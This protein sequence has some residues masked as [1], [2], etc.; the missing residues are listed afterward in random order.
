MVKKAPVDLHFGGAGMQQSIGELIRQARRQ[1]NITQTELGGLRF[2][3]SYVSAVERNK[4][5]S[6][7]DALQFFA[8][9]LGQPGDY[10]I[11]LHQQFEAEGSQPVLNMP[12]ISNQY[13]GEALALLD[14]LLE[15]SESSDFPVHHELP[16]LAPELLATLP[17]HKQS[18]YYF[19]Q[20]L[21]AKVRQDLPAA[22]RSFEAALVFATDAQ[23]AL[24]LDEL[25][26]YYYLLG[27][28][29]TALNYHSRALHVLTDEAYHN[30]VPGLQFKIE[31]HCGDDYKA[32]GEYQQACDHYERARLRLNSEHDMKTAGLLYSSLGYCT[33]TT[34]YQRTA[35][36]SPVNQRASMEAMEQ[37]FQRAIGL[38]VQSRNLHQIS[39]DTAGETYVR[40]VQAQVLLDLSGRRRQLAL[41]KASGAATAVPIANC[42][43]S[44]REAEEQC[45]QVL[46][47]WP[48]LTN[49][50]GISI[51][52]ASHIYTALAFLIRIAVQRAM[53]GRL[54]GYVDTAFRE[55]ALAAY[56]CQ[57]V[58]NSFAESFLPWVLIQNIG[59]LNADSI[60]YQPP[61]LPKLPEL[62][63]G[64][65]ASPHST[66]SQIEVY[67]AAGEVA[68][69]LGRVTTEKD[70]AHSCYQRAN[71]CFQASL[72]LAR[73]SL[74]EK[75]IEQNYVV[76]CYQRCICILE[77]RLLAGSNVP[78]ETT[79]ILLNILE[80]AFLQLSCSA[81]AVEK[82]AS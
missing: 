74:S 33:Y 27:A 1:Q 60:S 40:L 46:L 14:V 78:A 70:Y 80:E 10:F 42:A 56:L 77:E 65:K 5:V 43:S 36:S 62:E 57:E 30:T 72:D 7:A 66:I 55:R 26:V 52:S 2:S 20:G 64:H 39:G 12:G 11:S 71:L 13:R 81:A 48:G 6:S 23:Q 29:Q 61:S 16:P 28:Y 4:I 32:L 34:I 45:R 15:S 58:L 3:K 22:L 68:E 49:G 38:L 54:G 24:V 19:M 53:L 59:T 21:I 76:R 8:E 41:S 69:E 35:L 44:L 18:R 75:T 67:Y 37:E 51:E 47:N 82:E 79:R 17:P 9:Q 25:G 63:D 31:L 73:S 50:T